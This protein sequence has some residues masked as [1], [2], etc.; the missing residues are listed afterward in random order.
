P[1]QPAPPG[2][3]PGNAVAKARQASADG[4]DPQISGPALGHVQN[5]S[6]AESTAVCRVENGEALAIE[7]R[8]P[9]ERPDPEIA[10]LVLQDGVDGVLRQTLFGLPNSGDV[11]RPW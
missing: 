3:G 11:L 9:T 4:A 10:L 6:A 5:A 1:R 2:V 7:A 8:Q